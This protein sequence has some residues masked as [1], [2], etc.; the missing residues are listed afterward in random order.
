MLY[1][2]T[3]LEEIIIRSEKF[4]DLVKLKNLQKF[5]IHNPTHQILNVEH[6][7]NILSKAKSLKEVSFSP[8]LI[9]T[10]IDDQH[11]ISMIH[12]LVKLHKLDFEN[13]YPE[14]WNSINIH[15]NITEL[16]LNYTH[17]YLTSVIRDTIYSNNGHNTNSE[18]TNNTHSN[19]LVSTTST[20][21]NVLN[22]LLYSITN[23]RN[24][25]Q[26]ISQNNNNNNNFHQI[27]DNFFE[28]SM[29]GIAK[30]FPNLEKLHIS[31]QATHFSSNR[32][33]ALSI[34]KIVD[35]MIYLNKNTKLK[36]ITMLYKIQ[37]LFQSLRKL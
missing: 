2:S 25:N 21:G 11:L 12:S 22:N 14:L 17:R 24:S 18:S 37:N 29:Q 23:R 19:T 3:K 31:W 5:I 8:R 20:E 30:C 33:Y 13:P 16:S 4:K 1:S 6:M 9:L 35:N 36:A 32:D 7:Y 34:Q 10:K 28:K 27:I 15:K 26:M